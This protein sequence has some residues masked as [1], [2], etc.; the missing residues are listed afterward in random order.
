MKKKLTRA[1]LACL[2]SL[3]AVIFFVDLPRR[4]K[5]LFCM[6]NISRLEMLYLLFFLL[7]W[8][9]ISCPY[10]REKTML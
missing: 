3:P 6:H 9:A 2:L 5:R 7:L 1:L 10:W 4:S 8:L